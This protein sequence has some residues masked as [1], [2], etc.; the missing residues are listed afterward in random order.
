MNLAD[1]SGAILKEWEKTQWADTLVASDVLGD[2]PSNAP[3]VLLA[4]Q[5]E[6]GTYC[7]VCTACKSFERHASEQAR[8][9]VR[10]KA[11]AQ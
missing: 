3:G 9:A 1:N 8:D 11:F 2:S 5:R 4:Q 7:L 6:C 10:F